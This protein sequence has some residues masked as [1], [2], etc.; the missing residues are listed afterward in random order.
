VIGGKGLS[1]DIYVSDLMQS[2]GGKGC[3]FLVERVCHGRSR[4]RQQY[5]ESVV[6][7]V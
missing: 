3:F 2:D 4:T 5:R 1:A 7:F 6:I